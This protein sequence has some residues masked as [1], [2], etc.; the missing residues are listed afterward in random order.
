MTQNDPSGKFRLLLISLLPFSLVLG[1][2]G[3]AVAAQLPCESLSTLRV[4]NTTITLAQPVPAGGSSLAGLPAFCRVAAT[5]KPSADSEIKMEVW[6][7]ASGWNGNLEAN[8]NGG[9]SGS[10]NPAAL[11]AGLQRGYASAMSDLGHEGSSAS[12]ALGHPEKLIDFG[13]RAA[14]EMTVAAKAI[15]TSHYGQAPKLAYWNGCSAGGRSALM[16][17]QRFPEDFDGIV[18]G[19]PGLNWSGRALQ[20]VWIAQAAHKNEASFIPP[21]KYSMIHAAVLKAC[22]AKD[23]VEDGVLE[24]PTRCRFD[25]KELQCIGAD[26]AACLTADQVETARAIYADVVNASTN[27]IV[28]PGFEP[29]SEL[30]WATMAGQRPFGIG[31]DFFKYVV[32]KDLNWDY[33]S[34][35]FDDGLASVAQAE[36]GELNAMNANLK[37]FHD[38]GGK[39]IQYHGWSDPQISPASSPT[40]YN[41]VVA[42]LRSVNVQ[43]FYRL[44]MVPGMAHC[45]GGDGTSSFD[46]LGAVEQWVERGRAPDHIAS[47]RRRNEKV[48]RTRPLCPYPQVA[49]YKGTGS[50]DESA[51]FVCRLP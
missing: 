41:A 43:Q 2:G 45:G 31:A 14:H 19:A 10:I 7:P 12:F 5:L 40:Y 3:V 42:E 4:P 50:I 29:G 38:R 15:I 18:A 6:M 8:G 9:W 39:L 49:H 1:S 28:V 25:P 33:K 11:A 34:F 22:D 46:M 17:A 47:S 37:A 13:Y 16:E 21:A 23:G 35:R 32:F 24:D 36:N 27:Q 44:F 30:G 51:N 26:G 20:S 48:D